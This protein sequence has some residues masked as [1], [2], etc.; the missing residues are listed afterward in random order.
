MD[1]ILNMEAGKELDSLVHKVLYGYDMNIRHVHVCPNCGWECNDLETSSRCQACWG[2]GERVTMDDSEEMYNFHPS[3]DMNTAFKL[4]NLEG[5]AVIPQSSDKGFRWYTCDLESVHYRG[6]E[7]AL[8]KYKDT[9]ISCDS[10]AEA[11][12]KCYLQVKMNR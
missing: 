4:A 8:H 12:C 1:W 3:T 9:G 6:G 7:I 2:N 5:I 10:A 11:I